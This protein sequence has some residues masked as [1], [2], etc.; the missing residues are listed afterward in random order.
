MVNTYHLGFPKRNIT[1]LDNTINTM[2]KY[3]QK[4]RCSHTGVAMENTTRDHFKQ[5]RSMVLMYSVRS[6]WNNDI[7]SFVKL[8]DHPQSLQ[9]PSPSKYHEKTTQTS[10]SARFIFLFRTARNISKPQTSRS[11]CK[12]RI[13]FTV[14]NSAV[15]IYRMGQHVAKRSPLSEQGQQGG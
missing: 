2:E 10:S 13:L 5:I 4:R 12:V 1:L 7:S 3:L 9:N 6:V 8:M 15:K 11:H 14:V